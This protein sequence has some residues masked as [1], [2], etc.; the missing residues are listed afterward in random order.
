MKQKQ[1]NP[2]GG[3]LTG[4]FT[5][6]ANDPTGAYFDYAKKTYQKLPKNLIE[7]ITYGSIMN[8]YA[9]HSPTVGET[10]MILKEMMEA[11]RLPTS[12]HYAIAMGALK[13]DKESGFRNAIQL[14]RQMM[15][16][17]LEPNAQSLTML[18]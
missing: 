11:G 15:C 3:S 16:L 10:F 8:V 4:L 7:P 6:I 1:L 2:Q 17:E 9:K 14:W 13:K 18:L 5:A 12:Q